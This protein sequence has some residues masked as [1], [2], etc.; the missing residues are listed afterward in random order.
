MVLNNNK[1]NTCKRYK[2]ISKSAFKYYVQMHS[3]LR[4]EYSVSIKNVNLLMLPKEIISLR[5]QNYKKKVYVGIIQRFQI[6]KQIMYK[7]HFLLA[8]PF[9]IFVKSSYVWKCK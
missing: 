7:F 8:V 4:Y 3:F 1:L 6:L 9:F 5:K 2:A